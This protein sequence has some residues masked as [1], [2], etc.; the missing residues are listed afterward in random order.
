MRNEEDPALRPKVIS[1]TQTRLLPRM[2][3]RTATGTRRIP[4]TGD[5]T[6]VATPK[7]LPFSP[8]KSTW[9][10]KASMTTSQLEGGEARKKR[11]KMTTKK[12]VHLADP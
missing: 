8:T 1:E 9:K 4:F 10:G 5:S 12:G 3:Q 7:N 2:T 6:G 11:A